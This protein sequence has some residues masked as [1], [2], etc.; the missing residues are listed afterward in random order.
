MAEPQTPN[1]PA[2]AED[3]LFTLS[4]ISQRSGISM[5]TLQRYKKTYQD[6]IPSVGT[7][8]KQRYPEHA[9]PV[10]AELRSENAGKRGRP[11]KNAA[12]AA[13]TAGAPAKRRPGRPG[14]RPGAA[15]KRAGAAGRRGRAGA[16]AAASKTARRGPGRPPKARGAAP[17]R[18]GRPPG[19]PRKAATAARRGRPRGTGRVGRP[20]G[21]GRT[22]RVGRPP[23]SGRT[24]RVGRPPG[25]G[26]AKRA[27]GGRRKTEGLLT[28]TQ[29]SKT[30]GISYPTLVRYVRLY[31]HR[32][33]H[34]GKGRARRF[35]HEAVDVFRSLRAESGRGGRRAGGRRAAPGTARRG[36]PPKSAV[37]AAASRVEAVLARR[38]RDLEKFRKD[39]EKRFGNLAKGLRK[40]I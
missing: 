9:L 28:L 21:S 37:G 13:A 36:R 2:A 16:V 29:I 35:H 15:A 11:R 10:F 32:L 17:A 30:T 12:A 3:K 38:V 22:G 27:A 20:P 26:R 7:G 4:E 8:R 40:F 5:P 6:R 34:E 18:R 39:M 33:P 25:S 19:R 23:G 14:R 31:S 24:G 1:Q